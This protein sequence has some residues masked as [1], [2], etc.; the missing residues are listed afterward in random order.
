M[1]MTNKTSF[2]CSCIICHEAKTSK[3]IHSHYLISH[4]T[5]GKLQNLKNGKLGQ[6]SAVKAN[7]KKLESVKERYSQS[8][9]KCIRCNVA[10]EYKRRHNKFCSTSCSAV[11]YNEDRKG[12]NIDATR[13]QKISASVQ[14]YNNENPLPQYS[15]VSFCHQCGTVIKH[16]R[17][18][19][20]S[21][22]CKS[23]L[24]SDKIIE[25]IKSNRRSNYRRDK[26]SYLEQSF[27][28]WLIDNKISTKYIDEHFIKNHL[29][30][31]WYFV[32]YY[33]PEVNLIVELDGKQHEKPAHKEAD[34][35]RDVYIKSHLG[36]D[37]FRISYD[38][39]Q[40][41]SKITQLLELLQHIESHSLNVI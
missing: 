24:I 41:G 4:T 27:E 36:I 12:V 25:R 18:K 37:V 3:G 40:A 6:I 10:L 13:K 38:E 11:Y 35:L 32:D 15:K 7:N 8:P 30:G 21:E 16:S 20:C 17:R 28:Q 22:E 26:K 19:T 14:K 5:E 23:S 9:S 31:K 34:Q 2:P 39:Y 1:Y 29:T 33:F